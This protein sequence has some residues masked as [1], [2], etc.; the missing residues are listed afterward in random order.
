[1]AIV[2]LASAL[3]SLFNKCLKEGS[4][5]PPLKISKVSPIFKGKGKREDIDGYR[6]VSII[7]AV[8]KVFENGLSS[9]MVDFLT[10]TNAL[11][12]RQYAYRVG[13]STTSLTRE[14]VRRMVGARER[15][16]QVA[17]LCCDLSKAFD[18][19][20]HEVLAVKLEHYGIVGKSYAVLTDMM[21]G[22]TQVVDAGDGLNKSDPLSASMGVAQGSSVSNILFS[23]LLNDLPDAVTCADIL[24]Y[25]DDVAAIVTAPN[26]DRLEENLN[27]TASN[28]AA[29]FRANGLGLNLKKTHF[30][31]LCLSGHATKPL[32]VSVDG[33]RVEQVSRTTFLGFE[34]DRG[35]TWEH[36]I[37][38]LCGKVSSACFALRRVSRVVS[39]EVSRA[40][41]FATVHSRLQY[42]AELYGRAADWLRAFRSQKRAVRAIVGVSRCTSVRPYFKELGILTLPAILIFQVAVYARNNLDLYKKRSDRRS[43]CL[44]TGD[45]LLIDKHSLA[46]SDKLTHFM[47]PEVY[48][49]LPDVVKNAPSLGSFK[50]RLK[51]WLI[52]QTFYDFNEFLKSD[53]KERLK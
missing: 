25:A 48:N 17:V 30:V 18:V 27:L 40:C 5:P 21:R 52:E 43:C 22:R 16:Q 24:M 44:R 9:R 19:A 35:M 29:W 51:R 2:P 13:R 12:E 31:H 32:T 7:P 26:I 8:A 50:S 3:A 47:G 38:K 11:S 37:H 33:V 4:Y 42:G 15:R 36:H 49:R 6:P 14:L 39:T 45:R 23:L 34:I 10:D 1:M 20:D 46:K 28:L 41:Y 53:G